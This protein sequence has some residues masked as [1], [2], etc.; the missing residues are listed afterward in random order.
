[1]GQARETMYQPTQEGPR[2]LRW[3]EARIGFV[4]VLETVLAVI[5]EFRPYGAFVGLVMKGDTSGFSGEDS[6]LRGFCPTS[7]FGHIH[8]LGVGD[9]VAVKILEVERTR[10]R[11][12]VSA[13]KAEPPWPDP[14]VDPSLTLPMRGRDRDAVAL[15]NQGW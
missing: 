9:K 2:L 14:N 7:E 15:F 11:I 3:E 13:A 6:L 8:R 10:Q 4:P 5:E 1:M 12:Y